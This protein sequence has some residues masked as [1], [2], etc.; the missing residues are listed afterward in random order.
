MNTPTPRN[1]AFTAAM[2]GKDDTEHLIELDKF[3]RQLEMELADTK[4]WSSKLADIGDEARAE[5]AAIKAMLLDPVEVELDMIRGNIAIPARPEFGGVYDTGKAMANL[6]RERDEARAELAEKE[7]C[8]DNWMKEAK[9]FKG[10]RDRLAAALKM[11]TTYDY[12]D[13]QRTTDAGGWMNYCLEAEKELTTT[14]GQRDRLL[15]ALKDWSEIREWLEMDSYIKGY[16]K[17]RAGFFNGLDAALQSL[18]P[19]AKP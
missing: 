9:K 12:T 3:S 6:I 4:A 16:M 1:N 13:G 17:A 18:T 14:R 11:I 19:N 8:I 15:A 7:D 2:N 10:E 5:M